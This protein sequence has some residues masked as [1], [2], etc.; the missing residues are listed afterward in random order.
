M[1]NL[2]PL[3]REGRN[4]YEDILASVTKFYSDD[5]YLIYCHSWSFD[6][7]PS[8]SQTLGSCLRSDWGNIEQ[9]M[10]KF[11]GVKAQEVL[12]TDAQ[13]AY[14]MIIDNINQN[15]AVSFTI[16]MSCCYWH[17]WSKDTNSFQTATHIITAYDY[18]EAKGLICMDCQ[19]VFKDIEISEE[20][21]CKGF[22]HKLVLFDSCNSRSYD[23]EALYEGLKNQVERLSSSS[24]YESSFRAQEAFIESLR[25]ID[26]QKECE[27]ISEKDFW[28]SPIFSNLFNLGLGRKQFGLYAKHL[29]LLKQFP[30]QLN[31]AENMDK[32]GKDYLKARNMLIKARLVS[33]PYNMINQAA[34]ILQETSIEERKM[35]ET[36]Q[37]IVQ[38]YKGGT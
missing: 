8:D 35:F 34:D 12:I 23:G 19:P 18:N 1:I 24:I 27:D 14:Q 36:I 10:L 38:S 11:T 7:I 3:Y 20:L 15:K 16:K 25:Q 31:I 28:K 22:L 6:F 29:D 9:N 33:T 13:K 30:F 17:D 4:C 37:N 21:F 32:C 2:E 5:Y 26:I